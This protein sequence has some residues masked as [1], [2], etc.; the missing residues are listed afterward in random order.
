MY[1]PGNDEDWKC[2]P[3]QDSILK[4][5]FGIN[6]NSILTKWTCIFVQKLQFQV[7]SDFHHFQ[8]LRLAFF[9]LFAKIHQYFIH[10]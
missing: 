2:S 3:L 8:E 7:I 1:K 9:S 4:K 10:Q 5:F 6:K